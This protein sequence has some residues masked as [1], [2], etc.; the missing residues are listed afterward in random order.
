[1]KYSFTYLLLLG[2]FFA[3]AQNPLSSFEPLMGKVWKA[4]GK[5]GDGSEFR[6]EVTFKYDLNESIV[7]ADSKGFI[8]QEQTKFGNRNHGVR[9]YDKAS[10]EVLFWEFDAFGG[11]TEGT[12]TFQ[13]GTIIYT[14]SY[15]GTELSDTW[16]KVDDNTYNFVVANAKNPEEKYLEAKFVA[17]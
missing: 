2:L 10:G 11:L 3:K 17:Q 14:Y 4:E 15:S 6:Q 8:N 5:W 16:K 7:I 13:D 12:V 1:M 9:K